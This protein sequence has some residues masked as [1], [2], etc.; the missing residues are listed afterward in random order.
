MEAHVEVGETP[1]E[2]RSTHI[3][4]PEYKAELNELAAILYSLHRRKQRYGQRQLDAEAQRSV[5]AASQRSITGSCLSP[6]STAPL[7]LSLS[8]V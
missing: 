7:V 5:A 3:L 4:S 6:P 8:A 1:S 2:Q